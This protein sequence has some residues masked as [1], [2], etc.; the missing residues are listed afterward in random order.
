MQTN[1]IKL[2]DNRTLSFDQYGDSKGK[3]VFLF[4]GLHSS[5][6]EGVIVSKKMEQKQIRLIVFDRA[7]MGQ[8]TFQEDRTLF[9]TVDDTL[10]LAEHLGIEKFSVIGT[11]SGAKYALACAY[12]IPQKLE[13]V[14]CLSS[15]VTR[16]FVKEID[17]VLKK[18]C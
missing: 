17:E 6:L 15:A 1:I 18:I 10:A 11:S 4:H 2:K 3:P 13:Q 14:F 12:K 8:S 5:R 9:D 7:G 16:E